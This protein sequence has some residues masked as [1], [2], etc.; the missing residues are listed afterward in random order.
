[1]KLSTLPERAPADKPMGGSPE[2]APYRWTPRRKALG[3]L[4]VA[5]GVTAMG[6]MIGRELLQRP[7]FS[8]P[9]G[10]GRPAGPKAI[11]RDYTAR[12][13]APFNTDNLTLPREQI[14]YG[15]VGKDRIPALVDPK[16][17]KDTEADG[18]RAGERV[19]GVTVAGE[20]RA[21]PIN[22]LMYH[23]AVND[24]LGGVPIAVIY[25]PLCDS[26]SVVE[27]RLE[28]RTYTFGISGLLH[29]SNVLL[30]DRTDQ[31]L[32]SQVGMTAISGPNAGKSLRHLSWEIVS[33]AVWREAHP[34]ATVLSVD[35]GYDRDY[36]RQP[37]GDYFVTDRLSFPVTGEDARLPRKAPVVG[38]RLGETVRAYSL[39]EIRKAPGGLVRDTI[40]GEAIVLQSDPE[41]GSVRVVEAPAGAMVIHTFWFAWA[42][43]YPETEMYGK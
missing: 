1:M 26:V 10:D 17:I 13:L 14:L 2:H 22:I 25:C 40:D 18:L 3:L 42:A 11:L 9:P 31:A 38:V 23:E 36:R 20:S 39:S 24:T 6:V 5:V 16:T 43:F 32:W 34:E 29:N 15:G 35:T 21:Y 12:A 28:G 27:R 19:I 33:L 4:I 7:V 41:S 8:G 37:Y 30:F